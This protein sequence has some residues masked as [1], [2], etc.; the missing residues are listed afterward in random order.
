MKQFAS[1]SSEIVPRECRP[2]GTGGFL[3]LMLCTGC[4]RDG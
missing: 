2:A 4:D 3:R 1:V